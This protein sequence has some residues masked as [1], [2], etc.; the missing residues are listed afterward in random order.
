MLE[1]QLDSHKHP[2]IINYKTKYE[3]CKMSS[4][5]IST[6]IAYSRSCGCHPQLCL[7]AGKEHG[8][9]QVVVSRQWE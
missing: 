9:G 3:V 8:S 5:S 1:F 6:I 2:E 4:H 7:K